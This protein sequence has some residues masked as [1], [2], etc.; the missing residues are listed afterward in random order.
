MEQLKSITEADQ[1]VLAGLNK[2]LEERM[3][4]LVART[5]K[6]ARKTGRSLPEILGVF[7]SGD[8]TAGKNK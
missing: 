8:C 1:Q 3:G 7:G 5:D 4:L 2:T 6:T